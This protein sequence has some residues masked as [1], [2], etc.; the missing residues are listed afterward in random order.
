VT[1]R[2][3]R[4]T[5]AGAVLAVLGLM[6][7]SAAGGQT[8]T[9]SLKPTTLAFGQ[10]PV[11]ETSVLET[12]FTSNVAVTIDA[13]EVS[14]EFLPGGGTC[15]AGLTVE[16]GGTCSVVVKFAPKAE[17]AKRGPLTV[18]YKGGSV[19]GGLT[20]TGVAPS[21]TTT[22]TTTAPPPTSSTST[23]ATTTTGG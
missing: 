22:S 11:G 20:G 9:Q 10:V 1:S 2:R 16:A 15:V 14:P 4:T 7:G 17:G 6:L 12:T 23:T 18:L 5:I 19:T 21:P 3:V 8:S 13:V